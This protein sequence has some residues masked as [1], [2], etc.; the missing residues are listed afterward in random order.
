VGHLLHT[1][2][3]ELLVF[4]Y[5]KV[6]VQEFAVSADRGFINAMLALTANDEESPVYGVGWEDVIA[7]CSH[8]TAEMV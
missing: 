6:L 4:R 1:R 8:N 2:I 3:L 5:A 7:I